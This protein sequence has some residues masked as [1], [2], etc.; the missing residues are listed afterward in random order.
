MIPSI[1]TGQA[2][3]TADFLAQATDECQT[4]IMAVL[5]EANEE[6]GVA[7]HD[8]SIVA[9]TA[10]Y[11]IPP[12]ASGER[13]RDVQLLDD[14]E[15]T[16]MQRIDS[17]NAAD[18]ATTGSPEVYYVEDQRI[19]LVPTPSTSGTLRM[20]YYRQPGKLVQTSAVAT[21]S[22]INGARTVI[23][24]TATIPSTFTS[25]VI[26]DIVDVNP[27]FRCLQIDNTTTGT[28]SGTTIT[29]STALPSSVSAGDYVCLAGETPVPQVPVVCHSLLVERTKW[30]VL[31]A[32]GDKRADRAA[33]KCQDMRADCL[34]LLTPKVRTS[35]KILRN[36]YGPGYSSIRTRRG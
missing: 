16:T 12:R 33:K 25:G 9:S 26:V 10:S 29:L 21:I 5:M 17:K 8:V 24:T 35:S 4:Y 2:W 23:T 7:D 1:T 36:K 11:D 19:V 18:Y 3:D 13:L 14:G 6:Y 30:I 28:V 20:K 34:K 32:Q 31:D 27:G 22:S 15:Y